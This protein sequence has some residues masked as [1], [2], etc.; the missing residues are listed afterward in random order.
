MSGENG[1][2]GTYNVGES[3]KSVE[4]VESM[5]D[6]VLLAQL[7]NRSRQ[8]LGR[9][10]QL[11]QKDGMLT[12]GHGGDDVGNAAVGTSDE[13]VGRELDKLVEIFLRIQELCRVVGHQLHQ[14]ISLHPSG[15]PFES[16]QV[17]TESTPAPGTP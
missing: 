6:V 3:V 7:Q 1:E 11:V 12:L 5:T 13:V 2:W 17:R 8:E 15:E 9:G 14:M 10:I 4:N 16:A